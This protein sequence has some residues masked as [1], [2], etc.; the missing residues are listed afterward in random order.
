MSHQFTKAEFIKEMEPVIETFGAQ[1]YPAPRIDVIY[2]CLHGVSV[3]WLRKRIKSMILNLDRKFNWAESAMYE[4]QANQNQELKRLETQAFQYGSGL[5]NIL[6]SL[7]AKSVDEAIK[8]GEEKSLDPK[9]KSE[10][11][12]LGEAFWTKERQADIETMQDGARQ[13]RESMN[14]AKKLTEG[15]RKGAK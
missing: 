5:D 1:D 3:H 6:K 10:P 7:G 2:D 11:K 13:I 12:N 4:R 14:H 8:W 9:V 15:K